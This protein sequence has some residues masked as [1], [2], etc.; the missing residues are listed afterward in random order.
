MP[1]DTLIKVEP[2]VT[3]LLTIGH[4]PRPPRRDWYTPDLLEPLTDRLSLDLPLRRD[5]KARRPPGDA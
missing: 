3:H 2:A 1:D 4:Q 5:P